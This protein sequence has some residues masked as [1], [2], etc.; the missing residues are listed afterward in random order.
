MN[1][2]ETPVPITMHAGLIGLFALSMLFA[3]GYRFGTEDSANYIPLVWARLE[4]GLYAG[5]TAFDWILASSWNHHASFFA[6]TMGALARL[7]TVEGAFFAIHGLSLFALLWA[8]WLIGRAIGGPAVGYMTLLLLVTNR[9]IGGTTVSTL[10]HELQPRVIASALAFLAIAALVSGMRTRTAAALAGAA[11]LMHP[12][13]ALMALPLVA[14]APL[15]RDERWPSR[16][17]EWGLAMAIVVVPFVLWQLWHG[18][19]MADTAMTGQVSEAWQRII[20]Y[21]LQ[22]QA[23]NVSFW[24]PA[25]WIAVGVPLLV[26]GMAFSRRAPITQVDRLLGVAVLA[27]VALAGCGSVAADVFR[28]TL[29]SQL[30]LSRLLYLPIV[31]GSAYGGWWLICRWREGSVLERGWVLIAGG[32][33]AL[34][35]LPATLLALIPLTLMERTRHDGWLWLA[36]RTMALLWL[37]AAVA[38]ASQDHVIARTAGVAPPH[39]GVFA[40]PPLLNV[41][42]IAALALAVLAAARAVPRLRPLLLACAVATA[43]LA[44]HLATHRNM[45]PVAALQALAAGIQA[46][47]REAASDWERVTAWARASTPEGSRFLV[48]VGRRGFR[49]LAKRPIVTDWKD[50]GLTLFSQALAEDWLSLSNEIGGYEARPEAEVRRLAHKHGCRYVIMPAERPLTAE[51]AFVAGG[52][53]VYRVGPADG[54]R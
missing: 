17:R 10:P 4:P 29:G 52:L 26:W 38:I 49:A 36:S 5:D 48:P 51:R 32:A 6:E 30:M 44:V 2:R 18:G 47:W 19:A 43:P 13:S 20:N 34:G 53:A 45:P 42:G 54:S 12:I 7:L 40:D 14:V 46:P 15:M 1:Q 33:W 3:V 37:G 31:V 25:H 23:V 39:L 24:Q 11:T 50:G 9:A 22:G 35:G 27:A 8:W 16:L 41:L 21:R 28:S